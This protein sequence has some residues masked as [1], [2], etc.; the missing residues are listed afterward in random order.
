MDRR[1]ESDIKLAGSHLG[2][3]IEEIVFCT[4]QPHLTGGQ[5]REIAIRTFGESILDLVRV[6]RKENE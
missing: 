4:I 1:Q 5:R 3:C 2:R 6:I